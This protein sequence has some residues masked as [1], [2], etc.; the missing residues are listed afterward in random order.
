MKI[1][2][3]EKKKNTKTTGQ[4]KNRINLPEGR[5]KLGHDKAPKPMGYESMTQQL[6]SKMITMYIT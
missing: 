3:Q 6:C 4:N 5:F 1:K 2:N